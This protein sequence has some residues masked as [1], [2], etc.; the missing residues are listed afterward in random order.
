[1]EPRGYIVDPVQTYAA[2]EIFRLKRR[3]A[4]L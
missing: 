2:T 1:V 4:D 3:S